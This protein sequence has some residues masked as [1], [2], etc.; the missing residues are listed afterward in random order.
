M[1]LRKPGKILLGKSTPFHLYCACL[2]GAWLAFA[3]GF[4]DAPALWV[5]LASLICVLPVNM[6]LASLTALVLFPVRVLLL[7][8]SFQVGRLLLD[9]PTRPLFEALI[10]AP[11]T[12]LMGFEY[13]ATTGGMLL[14]GLLGLA[15][16]FGMTRLVRAIRRGIRAADTK[17]EK[18]RVWAS[19]WWVKLGCWL[20]FGTSPKA[21]TYEALE[22]KRVGMPVRPVGIVVALLVVGAFLGLGQLLSGPYLTRALQSGL[23]R[24]NGATVDLNKAEIRL[25]EGRLV[26]DGLAMADPKALET[27]LLRTFKLEADI[28][29]SDLLTRRVR[30]DKVVITDSSSGKERETPGK[31]TGTQP[32]PQ[33]VPAEGEIKTID[34]YLED[35]RVWRERLAQARRWMEQ[36]SGPPAEDGEGA[37]EGFRERLERRARE[38]GYGNVTADHLIRGAPLVSIGELR[39]EGLEAMQVGGK[40]IDIVGSNL[41]TQPY[42]LDAAPRLS[43]RAADGSIV[44]DV[45]LPGAS[46]AGGTNEIELVYTGLPADAI[47]SRLKTGGAAPL[48]G[49]TIDFRSKGTWQPGVGVDLPLEVRLNNTTMSLAGKSEKID[50]LDLPLRVTGPLDDPRILFRDE[51]LQK[52]L[53]AAGKKK[54]AAEVDKHIPDD[55]KKKIGDAS[56]LLDKLKR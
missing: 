54:L 27:D 17:S 15:V 33:D 4:R 46:K 32:E 2:F 22:S 24:V 47:G 9:G 12:A 37:G 20:I 31:L 1:L 28:S 55:V 40:R 25:D 29:T 18:Y 50:R 14:G 8:L 51:D 49:G 41:S 52:A 6:G 38:M 53:V 23:E 34:D 26:I 11:F 43:I 36:L 5:V 7:P 21:A 42:L 56:G 39:M 19:K 45:N 44:F 10:N 30:I 3:P 48:Q 35:A 16:G 13:Y